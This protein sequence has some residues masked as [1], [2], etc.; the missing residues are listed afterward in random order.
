ML[1]DW[2]RETSIRCVQI[3]H[4]KNDFRPFFFSKIAQ[5]EIPDLSSILAT[6]ECF[7]YEYHEVIFLD[8]PIQFGQG[9]HRYKV[10]SVQRSKT[11]K[12]TWHVKQ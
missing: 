6:C 7:E 10:K 3:R 5:V 9:V 4:L 1:V 2:E 12:V 8:L 11:Q